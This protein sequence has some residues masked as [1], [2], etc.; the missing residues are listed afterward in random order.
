ME[1]SL[2]LVCDITYAL[3]AACVMP[4]QT[5]P[6]QNVIM[7]PNCTVSATYSFGNHAIIFCYTNFVQNAGQIFWPYQGTTQTGSLAIFLKTNPNFEGQFADP[8]GQITV[9]NNQTTPLV[10]SC[11][12]GF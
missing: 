5:V 6:F 2:C 9:L 10:V 7:N 1:L 12:F 4:Q 8:N 3:P 11:Q